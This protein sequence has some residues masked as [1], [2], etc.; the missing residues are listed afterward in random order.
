MSYRF[1]AKR[2]VDVL[3]C[4][5]DLNAE[6]MVKMKERLARLMSKNHRKVLLNLASARRVEIAGLGMLVDRVLK[7]RALRGEIR[8]CNLQPEVVQTFQRVGVGTLMKSYP[9]EEEAL[10]SFGTA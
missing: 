2:G 4:E 7:V 9:T 3:S 6:E 10:A 1:I 5:G 8:L